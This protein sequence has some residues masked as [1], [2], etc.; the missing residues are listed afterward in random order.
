MLAIHA[1]GNALR[2]LVYVEVA[3][4]LRGHVVIPGGD[5]GWPHWPHRAYPMAGAVVVVQSIPP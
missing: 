1:P 4:D 3:P 2:A 5:G